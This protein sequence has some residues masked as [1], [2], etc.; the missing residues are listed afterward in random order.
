MKCFLKA[1][2]VHNEN[3]LT[4]IFLGVGIVK[5]EIKSL[6]DFDCLPPKTYNKIVVNYVE[7]MDSG[8]ALRV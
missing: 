1:A 3:S 8:S 7:V 6:K 5:G 4:L 2:Y